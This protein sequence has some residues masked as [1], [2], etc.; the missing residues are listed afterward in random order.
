MTALRPWL[1]V[2]LVAL[3]YGLA[4]FSWYASTPLGQVPVLDERE[5]LA[6][7]E[8]IAGGSLPHEPLYRAMGYPLLLAGL[9]TAGLP[10]GLLPT[11]A[12][13]LGVVLHA[14]S[15]VLAGALARR[16]FADD[17]AG[18]IAGLLIALNPV[19]VHY[20]T[21]R[22]DATLGLVLFLAGLACLELEKSHPGARAAAGASA[23]WAIATLIRPQFLVVWLILPA[24]GIWRQRSRAGVAAA[25][26][27]VAVG[28]VFFAAQGLWQK[29]LSGRF[30]ILPWQGAYNLWVANKPGANGRY[31]AQTL[32]LSHPA[33]ADNP[34][35]LESI[36][37]YRQET[38]DAGTDIDAMNAHWRRRFLD[39]VTGHPAAW[40]GL[41]ARKTYALLNDWEQYNNKT[42]AFHKD[43]S[44]WLRY[45][46]LGWGV[47]LVVGVA[48]AWRL[49]AQAPHLA[50]AAGFVALVYAAGT[51][52]FFVSARFRLPLAAL[53]GVAAG[54]ALAR[55]GF[56]RTLAPGR[57]AA[58]ALSVLAAGLVTFSFFDGVRDARPFVQDRLLAARAAQVVGDDTETW[59]QARAALALDPSQHGADEF[60]VTSGFNRELMEDLPAG[61]LAAWHGSAR[62]LLAAPDSGGPAARVIAA[63]LDGNVPA[64]RSL[65]QGDGP[66]AYDA[67]GALALLGAS[68]PAES[69]RLRAAPW[70]A[71]TTL[72]LWGRQALD[73][74]GF[75][76]WARQNEPKGWDD[77]LAEARQR[78]FRPTGAAQAAAKKS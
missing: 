68:D 34:A 47:L 70:T 25:L 62:Q 1:L 61:D 53:L 7:A 66:T 56:W 36:A 33:Q 6:L 52:L 8:Q 73:P 10:A 43:A 32:D 19:L 4:H 65:A 5:N 48:G 41:M 9:L 26:G 45:N 12:L 78:M 60:I 27:A 58:L 23:C 28:G 69:A 42:Y 54:G 3:A 13:L 40:L 74:A 30:R 29:E 21:Q 72:F 39:Y 51:V 11:A 14:V 38:G 2:A 20:A 22:L 57:P 75:A 16:W 37:L 15:A 50:R 35:R 71:G 67:L 49:H 24:L 44:P 59:R 64:L 46:P 76:A 17:R 55:P 18:L 31:Y 63:A 77:M